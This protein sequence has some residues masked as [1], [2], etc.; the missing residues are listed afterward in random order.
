MRICALVAA[1]LLWPHGLAAAGLT[2]VNATA[3]QS[4]DGPPLASDAE[5]TAGETVYFSFQVTGYNSSPD[6]KLRL[7]YRV[8]AFDPKGVP[9]AE[10]VDSTFDAN[11]AEEDS[12]WKPKIR[13]PILIPSI[14]PSGVYKITASVTDD[15]SHLKTT[16]E[17]AFKVSGHT[18]AASTELGL[19]NFGFYRSD[20][21]AQPIPTPVYRS[22]DGVF[23]RF[24]ITGFRYGDRNT[25]GVSYDVAVLNPDGKQ[26]YAQPKAAE[27]KSFSFYPKPYVPGSMSLSLQPN[28]R[29]GQY[30]IVLTVHD[31]VGH[32]N[33]ESRNTFQV[34]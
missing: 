10:P 23:A 3:R 2:I 24:D 8:E 12:E 20:N 16:A 26:I 21:D 28:T 33:Y 7:N 1:A 9:I 32:Q 15:I 19:R 5:F 11:L 22:G 29:P 30:T 31:D 17:A 34:E 18:I 6:K 13:I 4:E 27:E 25:V 14:V